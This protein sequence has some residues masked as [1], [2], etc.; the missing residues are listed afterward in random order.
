MGRRALRK[1]DPAL[2]LSAHLKTFDELPR[3]WSVEA[4]FGRPGPVE[5]DVGSG[6]GLFLRSAAAARPKTHFLG[7]EMAVKY[8]RFAA[9]G[10][11]KDGLSNARV[12]HADAARV[13]SDLLPDASLAAVHV[14]FPDPWWK[15]RHAKRRI[16]R[17]SF[18]R[19]V[20]RT[21][22]AGGRLHFWTD[23]E[24]YFRHSLEVLAAHTSLAGPESE[25]EL[26]AESDLDYRTHFERRMRLHAEPVFRARFRKPPE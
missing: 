9:A 7:I 19:Q 4:L 3:P 22:V 23:V 26:P 17:A 5:V 13:F 14:Y 11:V 2:D 25:P 16:M 12:V 18:V 21:L 24:D 10:L 15:K 6:K 8:A 20:E 1:I